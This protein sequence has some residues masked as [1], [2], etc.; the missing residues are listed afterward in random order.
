MEKLAE[1]EKEIHRIIDTPKPKTL[2]SS[3]SSCN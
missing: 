3:E 2:D 1:I